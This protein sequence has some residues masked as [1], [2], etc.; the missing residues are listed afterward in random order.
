MN[1]IPKFLRRSAASKL[2]PGE[3][4]GLRQREAGELGPWADVFGTWEPRNVNAALLEALREAIPTLDGAID[5][6]VM[7]DGIVTVEAESDR[8]Q[9]QIEDFTDNVKVGDKLHGLQAYANLCGNELYEQGFATSEYVLAPDMRDVIEL[10]VSDSK[11]ILFLRNPETHEL[12]T[13]RRAPRRPVRRQDGLTEVDNILRDAYGGNAEYS[14]L[15]QKL[16]GVGYKKLDESRLLYDGLNNEA[17]NPY[18]TSLLRSLPFVA[19]TLVRM[20]VALQQSW[21]RFGDPMFHIDYHTGNHRI[22]SEQLEQRRKKIGDDFGA[23]L[24]AKR[25][26]NSADF[27]TATGKDDTISVTIV[28]GEQTV[29]EV[30]QPAR[31]VLEQIVSKLNVPSWLLG[32]HWSTAERLAEKQSQLLLQAAKTR[33]KLRKGNYIRIVTAALRARGVTWRPGDW[34]LV[35]DLPNISNMLAEAQANFLNTQASMM[36]SGGDGSG[37]DDEDGGA[38]VTRAGQIILPTDEGYKQRHYRHKESFVEEDPELPKIERATERHLVSAWRALGTQT[39]E[40]LGLNRSTKEPGDEDVFTFDPA[41]AAALVVIMDRFIQ[42]TGGD[43]SVLVLNVIAAWTRGV[44]NAAAEVGGDRVTTTIRSNAIADIASDSLGLVRNAVVRDYRDDI[45][46]ALYDGAYDGMNPTDVARALRKRFEAHEY[47]WRRLARTEISEAQFRGK[48]AQYAGHGI[49]KYDW[50]TAPDACPICVSLAGGGP[51]LVGVG[52]TPR[53]SSH[54][55]CRCTAEA[56]LG[57]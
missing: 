44:T 40:A 46:A 4:S 57:E 1:L 14:A 56:R 54:P 6:Y 3:T 12:E 49:E 24:D 27:V 7:L 9:R 30:E 47:N 50:I 23:M 52:P 39:L 48:L 2:L 34:D 25:H 32:F 33:W 31:H 45:I 28:G 29:L 37:S 53:T 35:Q 36:R 43:D 38:K 22:T 55:E 13:W 18:G 42:T 26:G 8:L 11:N 15:V 21:S 41:D 20:N 10:R 51:Y 19:Q 17:E 5:A 16:E